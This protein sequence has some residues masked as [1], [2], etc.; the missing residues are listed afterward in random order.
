MIPAAVGIP[1]VVMIPAEVGIR[2]EATRV[3][4]LI[5]TGNKKERVN[6]KWQQ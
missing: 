6:K 3:A 2:V 5:M 4:D 1:V